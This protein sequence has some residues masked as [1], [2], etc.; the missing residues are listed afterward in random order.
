MNKKGKVLIV[1]SFVCASSWGHAAY[2][3]GG[4]MTG[5][6]TAAAV[7][8]GC[9]ILPAVVVTLVRK[10][11]ERKAWKD[12]CL[13]VGAMAPYYDDKERRAAG[14]AA[15]FYRMEKAGFRSTYV[16]EMWEKRITTMEENND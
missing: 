14:A 13:V 16:R 9:L 10:R 5:I 2:T 12:A 4:L 7:F 8:A 11:M 15:Y 3:T 6:S 1:A